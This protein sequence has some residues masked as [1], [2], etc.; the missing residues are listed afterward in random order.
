MG[1][2]DRQKS[3]ET[4]EHNGAARDVENRDAPATFTGDLG[5]GGTSVGVDLGRGGTT[6]PAGDLA[7]G[8]EPGSLVDFGDGTVTDRDALPTGGAGGAVGQSNKTAPS[9]AERPAPAR[10]LPR[11]ATDMAPGI[12]S[13]SGKGIEKALEQPDSDIGGGVAG[14]TTPAGDQE[15]RPSAETV[16]TEDKGRTTL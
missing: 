6:T 12:P 7:G 11:N 4:P 5:G 3:D 13:G 1:R 2:D 9:N 15:D 16:R 14:D 8:G 10:D